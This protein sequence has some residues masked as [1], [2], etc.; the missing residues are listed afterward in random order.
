MKRSLCAVSIIIAVRFALRLSPLSCAACASKVDFRGHTQSPGNSASRFLAGAY[1]A[2]GI[3][4]QLN[5]CTV[6]HTEF[7][8]GRSIDRSLENKDMFK[9]DTKECQNR[10]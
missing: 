2:A 4:H 10:R 1:L 8:C 3:E 6:V 9:V 7:G 5:T